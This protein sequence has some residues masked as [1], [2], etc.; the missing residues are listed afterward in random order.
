MAENAAINLII[1][2]FKR[3]GDEVK[4]LTND[5]GD[6]EK[7]I[8][9]VK[10][11]QE[12]L[13]KTTKESTKTMSDH[14]RQAQALNRTLAQQ[15]QKTSELNK[16]LGDLNR[17]RRSGLATDKDLFQAEQKHL[18]Y[19]NQAIK[20]DRQRMDTIH[21]LNTHVKEL[22]HT[23]REYNRTSQKSN[24]ITREGIRGWNIL[25]REVDD[26]NTSM[27][28]LERRLARLGRA[29]M[30]L[31]IAG[32]LI[33]MQSLNSAIVGL[34]GSAISLASSLTYAA[35]ALGGVFVAAI[36][37]AIPIIGLLAATMQRLS[38]IQQFVTANQ[39]QQKASGREVTQDMTQQAS[40]ADS[41]ANAQESVA[42]AQR[43][44]TEARK[45]AR[46]E[47]QDLILEERRAT[48]S[49]RDAQSA[50]SDA[51]QSGDIGAVQSAQLDL[52][53]A[54]LGRTRSRQDL[55]NARTGGPGSPQDRVRDATRQ[56]ADATRS[57]AAAHRQATTA[58]QGQTAAEGN[59]AFFEKQLSPAEK[60][61]AET[62][63]RFQQQAKK[64]ISPVTDTIINSFTYAINKVRDL[65][66]DPQILNALKSLSKGIGNIVRGITD[67]LTSDKSMQF[68]VL[69]I[70]EAR[71]NLGPVERILHNVFTI[72]RNIA[73][74][75]APVLHK[76]LKLI[77]DETG[78][79]AK[80][81]GDLEGLTDFFFTGLK[82]LRAW[83]G[84]FKAI[85]G[86]WAE[87]MGLS[88]DSAI[89]TLKDLTDT[90]NG[91]KESLQS[92][93]KDGKNFFQ[94]SAESISYIGDVL[95]A[96][97]KGM[98]DAFDPKSVK[99][100]RD[101]LVD[102]IIPGL[103]LG[104]KLTGIFAKGLDW[105]LDNVPFASE[106][107]KWGVAI[108][109]FG[110]TL[111]L[112]K[113]LLGGILGP[114]GS[115]IDA[116]GQWFKLWDNSDKPLTKFM[117]AARA[118]FSKI[119]T[120]ASA[121]A[122]AA[123]GFI[124]SF[125]NRVKSSKAGQAISKALKGAYTRVALWTAAGIEAA[126][127]FLN[128]F[129]T[130]MHTK[131]TPRI[132]R[133][134][135]GWGV[136]IAAGIAVGIVLALTDEK[137][138]RQ[139]KNAFLDLVAL[140]ADAWE[141]VLN[142]LID[143]LNDIIGVAN[144]VLPGSP[145]GE[146]G[147][148]DWKQNE[149][150]KVAAGG[151]SIFGDKSIGLTPSQTIS[152]KQRQSMIFQ[153]N[154]D[155]LSGIA[156][157]D[158][159]ASSAARK[160]AIKELKELNQQ[161]K[162][163]TE[164]QAQ[165]AQATKKAAKQQEN[166]AD[167]SKKAASQQGNLKGQAKGVTDA[168]DSQRAGTRKTNRTFGILFNTLFG[169]GK[170]SSGLGQTIK[171]VTN[172]VLKGFGVKQLAFSVPG[173]RNLLQSMSSTAPLQDLGGGQ[174]GGIFGSPGDR[175][176]D[177]RVIKVAGGE[178][179]LT[180]WHQ[181][182][183]NT[184]FAIA[185]S[186]G[187]PFG[188][189]GQMFNKDKREHRTAP[190]FARGGMVDPSYDPGN[191]VINSRIVNIFGQWARRYG[192][193]IT[194]G[195]DPGGGHVSPGHNVTGT[196]TDVVPRGGWGGHNTAMF[197]K[198]LGTLVQAGFEVLYSGQQGTIPYANHGRNNHAHIEWIGNG[199]QANA[200]ARLAAMGFKGGAMG[201]ATNIP[202]LK[203][204]GP[205]G[206]LRDMLQGQA[207]ALRKAANKKISKSAPMGG[208]G[209]GVE[210]AEITGPIGKFNH[211]FPRGGGATLSPNVVAQI[212]ESVGLPGITFSQ[213]AHGES[214]Y[215]PG[216]VSPD[217]GYGL[218][219]ITPRVHDA[220]HRALWN[221]IGSFFNPFANAQMA[222]V[223]Y[224]EAGNTIAPWFGTS[225]VT[226]SNRHVGKNR[227]GQIPGFDDGGVVPGPRGM[228]QMVMAHGGETFLPTHK[229]DG[230]QS[231]GTV[232]PER[233][234]MDALKLLAKG[235]SQI[236]KISKKKF[237]KLIDALNELTREEGVIDDIAAS[238]EALTGI[239]ATRLTQWSLKMRNGIVSQV[240][241]NVDIANR[242]L[243][244]LQLVY[245]D[246]SDEFV[247]IRKNIQALKKRIKK[248]K[249]KKKKQQLR[250]VLDGLQTRAQEV[251]DA[252]AQQMVDVL[253]AQEEAWQAVLDRFDQQLGDLD[254][255]GQILELQG[256]LSGTP[257]LAGMKGNLEQRG[258]LLQQER[259][260]IQNQLNQAIAVGNIELS[261]QLQT[262]LL[263]NQLALLQNTEAI[264]ELDGTL[265][266]S[267]SFN[268]TAWTLFR[269]AVLNGMGGLLPNYQALIPSLQTGGT[270]V[271]SGLVQLHSGEVVHDKNA[272][273]VEQHYHFTEPME[274]A[275]PTVIGAKIAWEWKRNKV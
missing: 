3:G 163:N 24:T 178:A 232:N 122:E 113:G 80:S 14:D 115:V 158:T 42:D 15:D 180:G 151:G 86:L 226:S 6:F 194:A 177:D 21:Q 271:K 182:A 242:S 41:L 253:A 46:R 144:Q 152:P 60:R 192:A 270:V 140:F 90:I 244:N 239:L 235:P 143:K 125:G 44:L 202:K 154:V 56:L 5:M 54:R 142:A 132:K 238:I 103:V 25:R 39:A 8:D 175:G 112:L 201:M 93:K 237:T 166:L 40:A 217:G 183:A 171:E 12:E 275:D 34:A 100:L 59:L 95:V 251:A 38:V 193:D 208:F 216:A 160:Q 82:H 266:E 120:W 108:T 52:N 76:L 137:F 51:M 273:P 197:E 256:K 198:G 240:V 248:V 126:S 85:V 84:L 27:A 261:R 225:F 47:L 204:K 75:A 58:A 267:F 191:E 57:L 7:S 35:G 222:K 241:T 189:L 29:F 37:Q 203:I 170:Q 184:A 190:G 221:R 210:G 155:R 206:P 220:A 265:G 118:A 258:A 63:I 104:I 214:G 259:E 33:F 83:Y 268:T 257:D 111:G 70:R 13:N 88:G 159:A 67:D 61:L 199:T 227:G 91:A 110:G 43:N 65:V 181:K 185:N 234:L 236:R 212:A 77:A 186:M 260:A 146:L 19:Q 200:I 233:D 141:A 156:S 106:A 213:I 174:T 172:K 228:P 53:E 55:S 105:I 20:L 18:D 164:Q 102:A 153:S 109:I 74:A 9:R 97:G 139:V 123:S 215:R 87:L 134:G 209:M 138:K 173:V 23:H 246:L 254:L 165:L 207:D 127:R 136:L 114:L 135:R 133:L 205:P 218:W 32:V 188:S 79:W 119:S 89:K 26:N 245:N 30:G 262:A 157:G 98:I 229:I 230:F 50:L 94:E 247:S 129:M 272:G 264:K 128:S 49:A 66:L 168:L 274:V 31:A 99:A 17:A 149:R 250:V 62:I 36:A 224:K 2:I 10:K 1:S 243:E 263:E 16:S 71:K 176:P 150:D 96:L 269:Q 124:T 73:T 147:K 255:I 169:V 162:L 64:L 219:Q 81:T 167:G 107:V 249:D 72:F 187:F 48:L 78:R 11:R 4:N 101:L 179:I 116:T 117:K 145:V 131:V 68:W 92:N 252:L 69:M 121:G 196:A 161:G 130:F 148:F 22:D 223:L 28:R 195:Y 45:D 231:G 211:P